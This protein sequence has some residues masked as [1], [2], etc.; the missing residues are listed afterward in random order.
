MEKEKPIRD[1]LPGVSP[2]ARNFLLDCLRHDAFSLN[3]VSES[4]SS[5]SLRRRNLLAIYFG[6]EASTYELAVIYRVSRN[7]ITQL[8]KEELMRSW[9][10]LPE[11]ARV[12]YDLQEI[13]KL[14][15]AH[16]PR[17]REQL[18]KAMRGRPSPL[19]G[20]KLSPEVKEKLSQ[21]SLELWKDPIFRQKTLKAQK[22]YRKQKDGSISHKK[23]KKIHKPAKEKTKVEKNKKTDTQ[24]KNIQNGEISL[25]EST[26]RSVVRGFLDN[27]LKKNKSA[28]IDD[29][30]AYLQHLGINHNIQELS[31]FFRDKT[32]R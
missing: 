3:H 7:R 4:K 11:E 8:L 6:S 9:R 13:L 24:K 18:S 17:A 12:K 23:P 27:K 20:R 15:P 5:L 29:V 22:E 28:T 19:R 10:N 1:P 32:G 30:S 14:K 16:T 31:R 25:P 26:L 2:L 21:Q